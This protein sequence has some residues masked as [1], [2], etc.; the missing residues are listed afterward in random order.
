M[1]GGCVRVRG[2]RGVR[3][4]CERGERGMLERGESVV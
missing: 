4:G 3:E 2:A 1:R